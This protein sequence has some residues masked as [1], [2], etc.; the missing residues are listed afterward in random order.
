LVFSKGKGVP[1]KVKRMKKRTVNVAL[2]LVYSVNTKGVSAL[3]FY[4]PTKP[5]LEFYLNKVF[6]PQVNVNFVVSEPIPEGSTTAGHDFDL[7]N[8]GKLE[9]NIPDELKAATPNPKAGATDSNFNIDVWVIGG[10]KSLTDQVGFMDEAAHGIAIGGKSRILIDGNETLLAPLPAGDRIKILHHVIAHEIGHVMI[11]L[12]GHPSESKYPLNLQ[13]NTY[14]D[15]Y[16]T[17]RLMCPGDKVDIKNPG[18]CL[19]KKE[20]D[21]I[22]VWLHENVDPD[23][24]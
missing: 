7:D 18:T 19:I 20:W 8:D 22:E 11:D 12:N 5:D 10:G 6:G 14:Y 2:H 1:V 17:K 13:W 3:P 15:P 16:L 4:Q 23:L 9:A 21:A 24:K